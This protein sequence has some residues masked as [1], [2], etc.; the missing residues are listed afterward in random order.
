MCARNVHPSRHRPQPQRRLLSAS[1]TAVPRLPALMAD[2]NDSNACFEASVHNRVR[3]DSQRKDSS[4]LRG[5]CAKARMTDQEIGDSLELVEE[6]LGNEHADLLCIEIHGIGDILLGARVQRI[7]HRASL[8][9]SRCM[10][11]C[12][13]TSVAQPDCRAASL[14]SASNSQAAST[15]GS[16]SRLAMSRPRRCER[17]AGGSFSASASRTSSFVLMGF[18]NATVLN[19][20]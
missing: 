8:D 7:L 19:F 10:A 20:R 14:R 6:A 17:S 5:G 4:A 9:R 13:E 16:A 11:S 2:N 1:S 18:S 15:S 3:K 12:A